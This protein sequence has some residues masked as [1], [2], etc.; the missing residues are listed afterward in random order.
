MFSAPDFL[1]MSRGRFT[2]KLSWNVQN[3]TVRI[4]GYVIFAVEGDEVVS[5]RINILSETESSYSSE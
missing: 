2:N 5:E 4:S 1:L 3:E